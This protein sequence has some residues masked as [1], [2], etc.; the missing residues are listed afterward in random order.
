MKVLLMSLVLALVVTDTPGASREG[1]VAMS[2][3][4]GPPVYAARDTFAAL[5]RMP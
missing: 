2:G 4:D 3:N 1:A 5:A